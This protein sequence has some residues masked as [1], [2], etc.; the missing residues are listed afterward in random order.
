MKKVLII[1]AYY[2][3]TER[4]GAFRAAKFAKNLRHYD[5]IPY[6]LTKKE[7]DQDGGVNNLPSSINEAEVITRCSELADG[8]DINDVDVRWTINLAREAHSMINEHGIDVIFH[9]GEPF[10]PM[11]ASFLME[12]IKN[13]PYVLDLRD[14]WSLRMNYTEANGL[15]S[16]LY[17]GLTAGLEPIVFNYADTVI[18]NTDIMGSEYKQKY[19]RFSSQFKT[20]T[21]GFDV[22]DYSHLVTGDNQD[23]FQI[24]YPGKFYGD[25]QPL[26][27]ALSNVFDTYPKAKFVHLGKPNPQL[28][29]LVE[30]F[31]C[32]Q[33]VISRGYVETNEV[34]ETLHNSDLGLALGRDIT[35]VPMKVYDY[36]GCN[37][38]ILAIGPQN[39]AL[40]G[41]VSRFEGGYTA[42]RQFNIIKSVMREIVS[43]RQRTL[44]E[45]KQLDP[46]KFKNL[47]GELAE[48][49]ND[50]IN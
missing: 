33:N 36:M 28:Q 30:R 42:D 41:L 5:W 14:P 47:T 39:G 24:I 1:S 11:F 27:Q 20:I 23:G 6:I 35:H 25:L 26:I 7:S 22:D 3:P 34:V 46:Y 17:R 2:P 19:P 43:H 31:G 12:K 32:E 21:N 37:L 45:P 9:T 18:M 8:I 10:P 16:Y 49:L 50:A 29:Q 13:T 40:R 48:V 4:V 44:A 15:F 38:P